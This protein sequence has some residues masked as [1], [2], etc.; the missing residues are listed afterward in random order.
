VLILHA[1]TDIIRVVTGSAADIEPAVSLMETDNAAPPV[2]QD[3]PNLGP[4]ASITTAT[5]TTIA[6]CTTAN[7]RRNV[8]H[9]SLYNNHASQE[10]TCRVEFSDGTLVAVLANVN[11][12]AGELLLYTQGGIWLH[13]DSNGVPYP[14]NIPNSNVYNASVV[15]QTG[16]ATD[17]YLTGSSIRI[18]VGQLAKVKSL[19]VCTFDVVKT[20]AG[21]AAPT[22]ILR[23]GTAGAVGDTARLTFTFPAQSA[24]V[25]T[26]RFRVAAAFRTIGSGTSAVLQGLAELQHNLAA[27]GLATVNPA[28][29]VPLQVTSGGF[30]STVANLFLGLS[31]NGGASAAWTTQLVES[32]MNGL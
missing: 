17:T 26:G 28:G 4:L 30:D 6:D 12:L 23:V 14:S 15:A 1:T 3:I 9:I 20:A 10:T 27:T 24:V 21:T 18:P 32:R 5:T 25:D 2:V 13:Y 11:L 8:K 16:F 22:V 31:V 19:Y 29:F 7:R